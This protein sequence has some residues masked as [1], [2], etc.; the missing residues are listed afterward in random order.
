[1]RSCFSIDR[2][3]QLSRPFGPRPRLI[4]SLVSQRDKKTET[5]FR[6]P[7]RLRTAGGKRRLHDSQGV[8]REIA[9]IGFAV[10]RRAHSGGL[11]R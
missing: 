4:R 7:K 8:G 6:F 10:P 2:V 1:M 5:S 11:S 9:P 3:L